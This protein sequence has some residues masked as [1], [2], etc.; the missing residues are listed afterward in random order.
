MKR[1]IVTILL[2]AFFVPTLCSCSPGIGE[3]G[4]SLDEFKSIEMGMRLSDVKELIGG[5]G[6]Q[7]SEKEESTDE[8]YKYTYLYRFDGEKSG[9][10]EIEFTMYSYKDVL[11]MDLSGPKVS[12]KQQFELS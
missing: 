8:Y 9:Y 3:E 4:I 6:T 7:I 2:S 1:I 12:G 5:N 11:K 10:A